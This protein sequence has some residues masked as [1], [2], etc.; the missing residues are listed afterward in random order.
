MKLQ[1][2]FICLC[3]GAILLYLIS[4]YSNF[5][6]KFLEQYDVYSIFKTTKTRNESFIFSKVILNKTEEINNTQ[7]EPPL[8][9]FDECSSFV[10]ASCDYGSMKTKFK[11]LPK[12]FAKVSNLCFFT[13]FVTYFY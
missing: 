7:I 9:K 11:K 4:F 3:C 12:K 1:Y 2:Q 10:S 13:I 5:K 8:E 6:Q